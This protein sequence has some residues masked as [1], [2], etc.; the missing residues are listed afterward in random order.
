MTVSPRES[1]AE[2]SFVAGSLTADFCAAQQ[3]GFADFKQKSCNG[4]FY[5]CFFFVLGLEMNL[6]HSYT[7]RSKPLGR[8]EVFNSSNL[9]SRPNWN[10]RSNLNSRFLT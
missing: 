9:S 3:F 8:N 5:L 2:R 10:I 1:F 4:F 6:T 7:S